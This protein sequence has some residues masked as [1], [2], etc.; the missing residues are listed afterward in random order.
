M[1]FLDFDELLEL[2][3]EPF[4]LK[5]E[6]LDFDELPESKKSAVPTNGDEI[7]DF[8]EDTKSAVPKLLVLLLLLLLLV[9]LFFLLQI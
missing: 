1:D 2:K 4:E 8:L 5:I 3:I 9:L 6:S 7:L